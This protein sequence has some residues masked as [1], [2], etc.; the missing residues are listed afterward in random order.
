MK[1]YVGATLF[2]IHDIDEY[3][4]SELKSGQYYKNIK[5]RFVFEKYHEVK[6]K[7][8]LDSDTIHFVPTKYKK[9]CRKIENKYF[10]KI[11]AAGGVIES[12]GKLLFI[13]RRGKWDLP[14][15]KHDEGES[16]EQTALREVL[17]E[18]AVKT[19]IKSMIG[20][21]IHTYTHKNKEILK[22][23]FWYKMQSLDKSKQTPETEEG[24]EKIE[25]L[26]PE[27]IPEKIYPNTYASII[28]VLEI[29]FGR[30]KFTAK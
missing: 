4:F 25:W 22:S 8:N 12:E 15:G 14:K 17:E 30:K 18:C 6:E 13:F 20:E 11:T 29:Y 10:K 24:I 21:I 2:H 19:E 16:I 3:D 1:F 27:E 5:A 23:T 28:E 9:T 26:S 7:E